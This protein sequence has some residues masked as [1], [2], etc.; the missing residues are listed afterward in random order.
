MS[1]NDVIPEIQILREQ[2]STVTLCM[3]SWICFDFWGTNISTSIFCLNV[4]IS[5]FVEKLRF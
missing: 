4:N 5:H 1:S 2:L 3:K